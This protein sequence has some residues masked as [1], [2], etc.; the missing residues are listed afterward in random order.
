MAT[1]DTCRWCG[2]RIRYRALLGG[3]AL[4]RHVMGKASC[5]TAQAKWAA[6][7]EGVAYAE[8]LDQWNRTR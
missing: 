1:Y 4:Y 6:S 7:P 5:R 2:A 8:R 3:S